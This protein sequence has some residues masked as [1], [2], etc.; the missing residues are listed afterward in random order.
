MIRKI[1]AAG[2]VSTFAGKAGFAGTTDGTASGARFF[3]PWDVVADSAGN[4]YVSDSGNH[5]IRRISRQGVVSTVAGAA[6]VAGSAD[7]LG[8]TARFRE[9]YGIALDEAGT[10]YVA[11]FGNST[12]R[13][14]SPAGMV[15]TLAGVPREHGSIDGVGEAARFSGPSGIAIDTNGMAY[16]TDWGNHTIRGIN[17]SGLVTTIAGKPL[18]TGRTDGA[19]PDA[20]FF[21]PY[22]AALDGAGNVYIADLIYNAIRKVS[23]AGTVTTLAG[24]AEQ[25]GFVA[26]DLPGVL[27]HPRGVAVSGST[28]YITLYN[29]V[30]VVDQPAVNGAVRLDRQPGA[31]PSGAALTARPCRVARPAPV[32]PPVPRRMSCYSAAGLHQQRR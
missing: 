7:G 12:V 30:A 22:G 6:G 20:R 31:R 25:K 23:P 21:G 28:L 24:V 29:G 19:G 5:T 10:L 4:L 18:E 26:G 13:T 9:P 2:V 14:I 16:V 3:G 1:S 15:A 11:D 17:S 27:G 32:A 8:E